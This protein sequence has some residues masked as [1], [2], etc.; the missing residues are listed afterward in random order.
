MGDESNAGP[1]RTSGMATASLVLSLL[2]LIIGPFG[3]VPGI[4]FGHLA[5][6]QSAR[7]PR[8][9]GQGIAL[10]GLIIGYVLLGVMVLAIT[11]FLTIT[12]GPSTI[13]LDGVS[14]T[15]V[16]PGPGS[17]GTY[18]TAEGITTLKSGAT[19]VRIDHKNLLVNGAD[20]GPVIK[21]DEV[22]IDRGV[23]SVNGQRRLPLSQG[24]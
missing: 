12:Q 6:R 14:I 23:V 2:G 18:T 5:R 20:F 9:G 11:F 21:G 22:R 19:E 1:G 17:T 3:C 8:I 16:K 7:N 13:E 24:R 4:V 15:I 10:A